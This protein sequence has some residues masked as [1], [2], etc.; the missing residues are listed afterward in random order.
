[1][2]DTFPNPV[3]FRL[4]GEELTVPAGTTIWQAAR[5]QGLTLPH[6]CHRPA[7]GY[8][9]DGNCRACMVEVEGERALVASCIRKVEDGMVVHTR[10]RRA[11][12]SRRLVM[13]LL[14][15]DQPPREQAHDRF[16]QLWKMSELIGVTTSRFPALEPDRVPPLDA[17]HVAMRVNLDA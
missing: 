14:L 17:S 5:D 16:S 8:R 6:L 11:E 15:A 13:E 7:S 3:T 9:P 12:Q 1:M 4:N 10:S 2:A